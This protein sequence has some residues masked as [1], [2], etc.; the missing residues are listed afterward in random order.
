MS[1]RDC[2]ITPSMYPAVI[3]WGRSSPVLEPRRRER[4]LGSRCDGGC[5]EVTKPVLMRLLVAAVIA[6]G[7]NEARAQNLGGGCNTDS[8]CPP[9]RHVPPTPGPNHSDS[10]NGPVYA[11][12][13]AIGAIAVLGIWNFFN[14]PPPPPPPP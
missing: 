9:P 13:G 1:G 8:V 2:I 11:I 7:A 6:C 12:T 14:P 4:T 5:C 3:C 10:G